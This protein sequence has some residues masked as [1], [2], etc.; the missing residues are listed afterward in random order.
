[1]TTETMPTYANAR[2]QDV[3]SGDAGI[4]RRLKKALAFV[5]K[6][7]VGAWLVQGMFGA[8]GA[9]NFVGAVIVIGWTSRLMQR[10]AL[11]IWWKHSQPWNEGVRFQTFVGSE[12]ELR[13]HLTRPNWS[14]RQQ[15]L[16]HLRSE[17]HEK[18]T[19]TRKA[20]FIL[21]SLFVSLWRNLKIGAQV[22]FCTWVVTLV[23]VM[24]WQFA[25]THGWEISF[26]KGYEH[27]AVGF[28]TWL[29]GTILFIGVMFYL[30]VAQARQAVSGDWKAFFHFKAV[31]HLIKRRWFFC[32]ILAG[33]YALVSIPVMWAKSAIYFIGNNNPTVE[34]MTAV[35]QLQFL[36]NYL[37]I[38]SLFI[39]LPAFVFLRIVATKIYASSLREAVKTGDA[40]KARLSEFES[41]AFRALGVN[42]RPQKERALPTRFVLWTGSLTGRI[43]TAVLC[44][45]IW[46]SFAFQ[47]VVQQFFI[48]Q[49]GG[50]GYLNHPLVQ[51][52][53]FH[54]VPGELE[55]AAATE[56]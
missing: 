27:S 31:R 8:F 12:E 37:F 34:A 2:L 28:S 25:W 45:F 15:F 18:R 33:L 46:F 39:V 3:I 1:M 26:T 7:L 24:L 54:F 53:F 48:Y 4:M 42:E 32:F 10:H 13:D 36:N 30:P 14:L 19:R 38:V 11:H 41:N 6:A 29:L 47:P 40:E 35:E 55:K 52:P 49:P 23:P 51:L 50:K 56:K 22:I 16:A 44:F 20:T 21:G 5:V 9:L 17:E 43:T